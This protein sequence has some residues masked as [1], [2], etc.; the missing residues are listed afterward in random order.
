MECAVKYITLQYGNNEGLVNYTDKYHSY[1]H[2]LIKA[3]RRKI[4]QIQRKIKNNHKQE[5]VKVKHQ[6]CAK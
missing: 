5:L 4:S 3:L 6:Y 1:Q 2:P